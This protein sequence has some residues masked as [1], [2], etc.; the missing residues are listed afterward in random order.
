MEII[1]ELRGEFWAGDKSWKIIYM[2]MTLEAMDMYQSQFF[3]CKN[4]KSSL[5]QIKS[6]DKRILY[7]EIWY[8]SQ[9]KI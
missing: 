1:G 9:E 5:D 8:R 7:K 6:D 2:G 4:Q 3:D